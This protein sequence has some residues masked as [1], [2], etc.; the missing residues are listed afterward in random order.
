MEKYRHSE[1]EERDLLEYYKRF[2]GDMEIVFSFQMCSEPENDA[3]RFRDAIS[4]AIDEGRVKSFSKF[5]KWADKIDEKYRQP[6]PH[7]RKAKRRKEQPEGLSSLEK[8][9][10]AM[11]VGA[12]CLQLPTAYAR[13]PAHERPSIPFVDSDGILGV[14]MLGGAEGPG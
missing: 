6:R 4:R 12:L 5:R 3:H 7:K 2:R 1:E 9:I 11:Q 14:W 10:K 8:Q 13:S